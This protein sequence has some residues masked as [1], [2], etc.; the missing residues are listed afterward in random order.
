MGHNS[1]KKF[2]HS[3]HFTK[4]SNSFLFLGQGYMWQAWIVSNLDP[5]GNIA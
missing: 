2:K 5:A 4:A 3:F 1:G